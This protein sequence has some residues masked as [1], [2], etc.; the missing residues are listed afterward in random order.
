MQWNENLLNEVPGKEISLIRGI[1]ETCY[2]TPAPAPLLQ[3]HKAC[4]SDSFK[5]LF[6]LLLQFKPV[7]SISR[8]SIRFDLARLPD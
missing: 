5:V 1:G 4:M 6:C 7:A 2:H 8:I 3:A